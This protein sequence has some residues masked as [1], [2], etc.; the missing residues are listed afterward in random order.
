MKRED[1][2]EKYQAEICETCKQMHTFYLV[3]EGVYCAEAE[4][5]VAE[6]HNIELID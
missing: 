2:R 3:C 6:A 1:V 4:N 5:M